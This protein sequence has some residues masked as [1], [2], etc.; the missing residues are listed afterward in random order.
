MHSF[1]PSR[2][3]LLLLC[4]GLTACGQAAGGEPKTKKT[5]LATSNKKNGTAS[6]VK[7][8]SQ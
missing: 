2:T 5:K 8:Q 6:S 1:F 7:T 4:I 3:L